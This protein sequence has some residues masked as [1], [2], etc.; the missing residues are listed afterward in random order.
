MS[1]AG[2]LSPPVSL[3]ERSDLRIGPLKISPSTRTIVG[4]GGRQVVE[5]RIM[6]VLLTLVDADGRVVSRERLFQSCWGGLNVGEDSLNRAIAEL[7][8][9]IRHLGGGELIVETVPRVGYRLSTLR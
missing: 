9:V 8:R 4:L 5:P 3:A 2:S 7:R 6:Q 1:V